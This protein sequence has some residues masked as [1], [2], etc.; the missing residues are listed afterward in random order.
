MFSF[1]NI[2]GIFSIDLLGRIAQPYEVI[3]AFA[4]ILSIVLLPAVYLSFKN[5][6]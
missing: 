3:P 4:I 2:I 1:D 6:M 5:A